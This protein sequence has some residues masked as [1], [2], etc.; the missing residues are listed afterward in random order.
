[1][2]I[3]AVLLLL[4]CLP[5]FGSLGGLQIF[6]MVASA[7]S[8]ACGVEKEKEFEPRIAANAVLLVVSVDSCPL[9]LPNKGMDVPIQGLAEGVSVFTPNIR[10]EFDLVVVELHVPL[11]SQ[12]RFG[13]SP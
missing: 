1:M 10:R 3:R 12:V 2:Q 7:S 4:L 9:P 6:D 8:K 5:V 11:V 13:F